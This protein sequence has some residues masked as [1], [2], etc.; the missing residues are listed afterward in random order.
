MLFWCVPR[1]PH[2]FSFIIQWTILTH[3]MM[4][5]QPLLLGSTQIGYE[6]SFCHSLLKRFYFGLGQQYSKV[7]YESLVFPCWLL[8]SPYLVLICHETLLLSPFCWTLTWQCSGAQALV[9]LTSPSSPAP[10]WSPS[11][12]VAL[13]SSI[14]WQLPD[15]QLWPSLAHF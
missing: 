11:R 6:I 9:H 1:Q 10:R 15:V 4:L 7:R 13:I 5:H 12:P 14:C 3:F 8:C 2:R